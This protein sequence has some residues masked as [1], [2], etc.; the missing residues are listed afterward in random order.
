MN[1]SV[2]WYDSHAD[3]VVER[4]ESLDFEQ[5]HG[6]QRYALPD[7]PATVLDIGAGSGCD[8]AW[9]AR[10]GHE[11]VAIEPSS[12]MRERAQSLHRS[13][14]ITWMD[15]RLPGLARITRTGL[16]FDVILLSAVWMHL[17]EADR[18]RAFR[19]IINL[20]RPGGVLAISLRQGP[21]EP[22]RGI[23]PVSVA[24]LSQLCRDHGAFIEKT[25]GEEDE[26]GRKE[27]NWTQLVI[28][29]PDDGTGALP[30]LRHI[31]LNDTKSS[32]YKLALLRSL[33]R[34]ADTSAGMARAVDDDF[35]TVPL[36]LVGL[37]WI[38]LF[39]PL[40]K[41]G[42]PQSPTNVGCGRLGFVKEPFLRLDGLSHHDLRI[43]MQIGGDFAGDLHSA[44]R[45]AV[46][47]ICG[48]P[49]NFLTYPDGEPILKCNKHRVLRVP[50]TPCRLD[51]PYLSSFGEMLIPTPLWQALQRFAVWIEPALVAEWI[52]L[53][54]EY[55][56]TQGRSLDPVVVHQA[57]QWAD[58]ARDVAR[59]REL[60]MA[61]LAKKPLH[62]VWTGRKL[63]PGNL[64]IDHGFPWSAWPCNDMWNLLPAHQ[65]VNR[66][67]K[68]HKLPS[69][70]LLLTAQ[71][72]ITEWWQHGYLAQGEH[73]A[74]QFAWEASASL[75]GLSG[76]SAIE[77][78]DVFTAMR[79]QR[80]RL[81]MNQQI[82]EWE[83]TWGPMRHE[84]NKKETTFH[85][86]RD[87]TE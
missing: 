39:K 37:T 20:L 43:G 79:L 71:E 65:Q 63:K 80:S 70:R 48:M 26:L 84:T 35:V 7:P 9:L 25:V 11:V 13:S 4:Y 73:V 82:P 59:T 54:G 51:A 67:Q 47:T 46:S 36:G 75:P 53:M 60:A 23:H 87:F 44:L 33:S 6:W 41:G 38:R 14:P 74:G 1:R 58:P 2:D 19:K 21:A 12:S 50:S 5:V 69:E 8:A 61:L 62:C 10:R 56:R 3:E 32:T 29:L 49:A 18:P 42:L 34:I 78:S 40:L 17:P 30:L 15:D 64:D 77:P 85:V 55:A 83:M 28:R 45:D 16:S 86:R 68:R 52:K 76:E 66:Q 72:R 57:M 81:R 27:V 22:E 31:I 24:E